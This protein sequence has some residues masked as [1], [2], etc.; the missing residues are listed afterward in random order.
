MAFCM[1][2]GASSDGSTGVALMKSSARSWTMLSVPAG[3][4]SLVVVAVRQRRSVSWSVD[5]LPIRSPA[6]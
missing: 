6:C 1:A 5:P 3:Q 2:V 4:K